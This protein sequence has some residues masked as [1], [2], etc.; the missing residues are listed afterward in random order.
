[1]SKNENKVIMKMV[2][3]DDLINYLK[4]LGVYDL[5]ESGGLFCEF[6]K[7][8]ITL[9]NLQAIIPYKGEIRFICSN[10][11]CIHNLKNL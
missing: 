10:S 5:L 8:K 7:N 6:C 9:K 11:E 2:Q 3:E 4:S 1:M